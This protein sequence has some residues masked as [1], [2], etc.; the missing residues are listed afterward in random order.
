MMFE[1]I[2]VYCAFVLLLLLLLHVSFRL[3][4]LALFFI[5]CC[6]VISV[7]NNHQYLT[8]KKE[9]QQIQSLKKI[10]DEC[11]LGTGRQG[12]MLNSIR[13]FI[14]G[15]SSTSPHCLEAAEASYL[16]AEQHNL[17]ETVIFTLSECSFHVGLTI[18]KF[19]S[20]LTNE[21]EMYSLIILCYFCFLIALIFF[22]LK[23]YSSLVGCFY[24]R[25][26]AQ[27][28]NQETRDELVIFLLNYYF[29]NEDRKK[30]IEQ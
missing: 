2:V 24:Y 14:L 25:P 20:G 26:I 12:W 16:T 9:V 23:Y 15:Y 6:F 5:F 10:Q 17:M 27:E 8:K 21:L 13:E 28:M 1:H 30:Q 4:N 3:A 7:Y 11:Q 18:I 22:I 29:E 19:F